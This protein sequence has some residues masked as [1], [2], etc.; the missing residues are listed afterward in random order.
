MIFLLHKKNTTKPAM[1]GNKR[2]AKRVF[3]SC[4][5]GRIITRVIKPDSNA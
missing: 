4:P 5:D 2:S 1:T 3:S